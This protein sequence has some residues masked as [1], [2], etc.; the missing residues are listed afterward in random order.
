VAAILNHENAK[1]G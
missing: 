1:R